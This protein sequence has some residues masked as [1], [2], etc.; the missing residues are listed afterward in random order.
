MSELGLGIGV[1]SKAPLTLM[2]PAAP[3]PCR[4][5]AS[6]SIASERE[7][8]QARDA[9]TKSASPARNTRRKPTTSPSEASGSRVVTTASW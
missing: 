5:R 2:T 3:K 6:V 7:S 4:V 1:R 8:A 9:T